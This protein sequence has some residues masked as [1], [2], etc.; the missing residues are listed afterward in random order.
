MPEPTLTNQLLFH[1][2]QFKGIDLKTLMRCRFQTFDLY[3]EEEDRC[4]FGEVSDEKLNYIITPNEDEQERTLRLIHE[5][6]EVIYKGIFIKE[7][8]VNNCQSSALRLLFGHE[9]FYDFYFNN[10]KYVIH[11]DED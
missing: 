4:I 10:V 2:H 5:D 1:L 7:Y 9:N 3:I 8:N 11:I 6:G